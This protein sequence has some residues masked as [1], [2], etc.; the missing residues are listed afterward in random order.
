MADGH[1]V[2]RE[3]QRAILDAA[4]DMRVV[5]EAET[6]EEALRLVT[7]AS[8]DLVI[9]DLNL[10]ESPNGVELCRK[11]NSFPKLPLSS[12]SPTATSWNAGLP[13]PGA[14]RT[15]TSTNAVA[16]RSCSTP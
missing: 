9:L 7:E 15:A 13:T 4:G 12:S 6:G 8:P 14:L 2:T 3:G 1:P 10:E 16:A 5:G 11:K